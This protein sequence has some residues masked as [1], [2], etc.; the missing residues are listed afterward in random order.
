MFVI[1]DTESLCNILNFL[2]F[3]LASKQAF[4][5]IKRVRKQMKKQAN[6][7]SKALRILKHFL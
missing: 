7:D 6:S 3:T 4:T 2:C 5:Q 1:L